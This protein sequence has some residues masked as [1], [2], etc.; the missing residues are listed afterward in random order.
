MEG[1]AWP[2]MYADLTWFEFTEPKGQSRTSSG[3]MQR[4][5]GGARFD[6]FEE[7]GLEAMSDEWLDRDTLVNKGKMT[8]TLNAGDGEWNG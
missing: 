5:C 7:F 1:Y 3:I 4:Y 2:K 6:C 8:G